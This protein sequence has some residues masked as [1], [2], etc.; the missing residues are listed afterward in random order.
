MLYE[1]CTPELKALL[2]GDDGW[3]AIEVDQDSIHLLRMIKGRCCKFDPTR[4][5]TRA[6]VA[7]DK[8]IMCY[9]Q[10]GHVTNSQYFERFNTLVDTALSYGSSIGHSRP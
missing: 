5:E 6:I 3:S 8:A 9:V 10:E 7:A 1:H 2:K 4:Q